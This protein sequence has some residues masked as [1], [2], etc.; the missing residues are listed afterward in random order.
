MG[1]NDFVMLILLIHINYLLTRSLIDKMNTA[2]DQSN[3]FHY[4]DIKGE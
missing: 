1:K 3:T 2:I 4:R